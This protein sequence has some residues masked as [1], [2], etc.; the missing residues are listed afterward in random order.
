VKGTKEHP[1]HMCLVGLDEAGRSL[2]AAAVADHPALQHVKDSS[3]SYSR[4][5]RRCCSRRRSANEWNAGRRKAQRGVPA[6][7]KDPAEEEKPTLR[8]G[9]RGGVSTLTCPITCVRMCDPVVLSTTGT[10]TSAKPSRR[11]CDGVPARRRPRTCWTRAPH[12]LRAVHAATS[13]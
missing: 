6:E 7:E 1:K 8:R 11:G 12:A 10:R 3:A 9:G 2:W 4:N 13:R 5:S